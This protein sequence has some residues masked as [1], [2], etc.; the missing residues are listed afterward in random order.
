[1]IADPA[2]QPLIVVMVCVGLAGAFFWLRKKGFV[3]AASAL[4][5]RGSRLRVIERVHL[6]PQHS[7]HLV[8]VGNKT[9]LVAASPGSCQILESSAGGSQQ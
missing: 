6:T 3:Q 9:L 2:V 4:Q 7:I 1:M 8:S 5:R